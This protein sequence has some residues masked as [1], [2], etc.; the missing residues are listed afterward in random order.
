MGSIENS[1]LFEMGLNELLITLY[2]ALLG[3]GRATL[4]ELQILILPKFNLSYSQIY[5]AIQHL[6]KKKIIEKIPD[7]EYWIP[8][9]PSF[10]FEPIRD[11]KILAYNSLITEFSELYT[12]STY[13]SGICSMNANRFQFS[14]LELGYKILNEQFFPQVQ[15]RIILLAVPPI[16]IKRLR[17]GLIQAS[18]RGVKIEIHYSERDFEERP[19]YFDQIKEY[20]KEIHCTIYRRKFR[21]Y[22]IISYN[23]EYTR[24]AHILLDE[25]RF[26]SFP[27]HRVNLSD[28]RVGFDIDTIDGLFNVPGIVD[29][30]INS[31]HENPILEQI[32]LTPPLE[33]LI[34]EYLRNHSPIQKN[35]ISKELGIA[36][37]QLKDLLNQLFHHNLIRI[38]KKN[39]KKGRP[40][41]E[42]IIN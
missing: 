37:S 19:Q 13:Q 24:E 40:I 36:G 16:V 14:S 35:Q 7:S 27:Y 12:R 11:D 4:S 28:Y 6:S 23:D 25:Q 18:N 17:N 34:L 29:G 32:D 33:S 2:R 1:I 41:E 10:V 8:K 9:N 15:K 21:I 30:I 3:K 31:F 5:R 38:D 20:V 26:I 42:I 22:D 39:Q